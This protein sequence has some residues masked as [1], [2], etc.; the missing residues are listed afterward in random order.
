MIRTGPRPE[1]S[2]LYPRTLGKVFTQRRHR[3][4]SDLGSQGPGEPSA[5]GGEV[6][7]A[8]RPGAQPGPPSGQVPAHSQRSVRS[9]DHSHQLVGRGDPAAADART[10]TPLSVLID[11]SAAAQP[12]A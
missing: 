6:D 10:P 2:S 12:N 5:A 7:A 3:P 9:S 11:G 4:D 1:R 8:E